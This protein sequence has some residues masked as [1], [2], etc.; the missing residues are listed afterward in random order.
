[1][2]E[3]ANVSSIMIWISFILSRRSRKTLFTV[4]LATNFTNTCSDF[5]NAESESLRKGFTQ[6]VFT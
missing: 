3:Q 5:L 1:M 4:D 2:Q 6:A